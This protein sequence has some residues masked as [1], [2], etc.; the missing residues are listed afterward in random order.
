MWDFITDEAAAEVGAA[1]AAAAAADAPEPVAQADMGVSVS[2]VVA[3]TARLLLPSPSLLH[4]YQCSGL[5]VCVSS[6]LQPRLFVAHW[7]R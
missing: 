6:V 4:I 5:C 3:G 7:L 1:A 2:V